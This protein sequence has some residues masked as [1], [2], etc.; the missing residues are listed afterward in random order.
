MKDFLKELISKKLDSEIAK[1]NDLELKLD[2]K[3]TYYELSKEKI[4]STWKINDI[5]LGDESIKVL[6]EKYCKNSDLSNLVFLKT[7]RKLSI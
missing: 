6:K 3:S 2:I 5:E 1:F 4:K 7:L